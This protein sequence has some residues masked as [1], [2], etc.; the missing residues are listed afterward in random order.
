MRTRSSL[1]F[2]QTAHSRALSIRL[3]DY[4]HADQSRLGPTRCASV[5]RNV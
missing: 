2:T 5:E 3:I 1:T 4:L